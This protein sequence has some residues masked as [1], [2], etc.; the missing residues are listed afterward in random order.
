MHLHLYSQFHVM[1][2]SVKMSIPYTSFNKK[3]TN[4]NIFSQKYIKIRF[5]FPGN[6]LIA[7]GME[8]SECFPL[9]AIYKIIFTVCFLGVFVCFI[10]TA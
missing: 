9:G 3:S 5:S 1:N 2:A 4:I 6:C 10:L 8:H 7:V